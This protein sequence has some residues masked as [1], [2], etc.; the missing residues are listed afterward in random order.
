MA[1]LW[2]R[3]T[4]GGSGG[5]ARLSDAAR[6]SSRRSLSPAKEREEEDGEAE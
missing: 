5:G 1:T 2:L 3:G 4:T 6:M